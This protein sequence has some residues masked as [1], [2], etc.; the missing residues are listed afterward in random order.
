MASISST[1][2][3][4]VVPL[5]NAAAERQAKWRA[6]RNALAKSAEQRDMS[7]QA[8]SPQRCVA[9]TSLTVTVVLLALSLVHLSTGIEMIT[10]CARWEAV[11][12]ALGVD[13]AMVCCE[14]ALL[15]SGVPVLRVI[16]PWASTTI[17][18]TVVASAG[19]NSLAFAQ[20]AEGFMMYAGIAAGCAV[21]ALIFSLTKVAAGLISAR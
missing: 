2:N 9:Y 16:K 6:K 10:H 15:V 4:T 5:R 11:A 19:L 21:P 3:D 12:L 7:R 18:C 14:A 8:F 13:A 20:T 1:T 17:I